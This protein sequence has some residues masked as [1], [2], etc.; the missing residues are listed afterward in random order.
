MAT[1]DLTVPGTTR[2]APD[3]GVF[4]LTGAAPAWLWVHTCPEP[5]CSC[6]S[7]LVLGTTERRD[8]LLEQSAPVRTAWE[9]G[10][11]YADVAAKIDGLDVFDLNI[12]TAEV[13]APDPYFIGRA[14]SVDA[15]QVVS[16]YFQ[17]SFIPQW[18]TYLAQGAFAAD[19]KSYVEVAVKDKDATV[20]DPIGACT[21]KL[22]DADFAAS[23]NFRTFSCPAS[24]MQAGYKLRYYLLP[25]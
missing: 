7:A 4:E 14:G 12:D 8:A 17:D 16:A 22:V 2:F 10:S 3:E 23:P 25:H 19:L 11:G 13:S 24:T 18:N 6:R 21:W 9:A 1:K 5:D 15:P 20:D